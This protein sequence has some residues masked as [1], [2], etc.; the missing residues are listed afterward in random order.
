[1]HKA[2]LMLLGSVVLFLSRSVNAF[3]M[4]MEGMTGGPAK[5]KISAQGTFYPWD[6]SQWF[7]LNAS[8]PVF[9]DE[10][11]SLSLSAS[12]MSFKVPETYLLS[13]SSGLQVPKALRGQQFGFGYARNLEGEKNFSFRASFGSTSDQPFNSG[14][15]STFSL[16]ASYLFPSETDSTAKWMWLV[17]Y[18]NNNPVF[19]DFPIPG[20][21][22]MQKRPDLIGV[23]GI[24]FAFVKW[25][26][27]GKIWNMS[28]L[29]LGGTI[30]KAEM[31]FGPPFGGP[32]A[33]LGL[34]WSQ[35][36]WLREGRAETKDKLYYD[37]KQVHAGYRQ[38]LAKWVSV[39]A[40][41]GYA[42]ER[43]FFEGRSYWDKSSDTADLPD[44]GFFNLQV[45]LDL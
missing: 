40:Q 1:M 11:Q 12:D 42:F 29:A 17:I 43:R 33:F 7:Q 44:N 18:S 32:N 14:D 41:V 2:K 27:T 19:R 24:P 5:T 35:H 3:D 38:P 9:K 15:V 45:K 25:F 39:E 31:A 8:L 4:P 30:W 13:K 26:P 22:Y 34:D 36:T 16:M 10:T 37:Q 23:Y 28:F 6:T 21:A 20:I